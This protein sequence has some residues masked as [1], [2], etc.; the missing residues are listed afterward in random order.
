MLTASEVLKYTASLQA[1]SY[2]TLD[3]FFIRHFGIAIN[4]ENDP[5]IV[6]LREVFNAILI[7]VEIKHPRFGYTYYEWQDR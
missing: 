7:R 2:K 4:L 1:A 5:L 3:Q 6:E